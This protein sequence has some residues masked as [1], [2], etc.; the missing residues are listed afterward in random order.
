ME[1]SEETIHVLEEMSM[2]K[3]VPIDE[4]LED[5]IENIN[6]ISG[7]FKKREQT[8]TAALRKQLAESQE[9]ARKE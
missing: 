9:M 6:K 2:K 3:G 4:C 8:L 7:T 1:L 5:Y